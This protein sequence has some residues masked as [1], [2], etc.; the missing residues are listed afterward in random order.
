M[1][2]AVRRTPRASGRMRRLIVS[3]TIRAGISGVGVPSGK[4]C[5]KEVV[6]WFRRPVSNVA[7]QS[8]NARAIFIDS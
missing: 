2:F 8:G 6:G 5:P 7:S 1:R 4:R 3:I